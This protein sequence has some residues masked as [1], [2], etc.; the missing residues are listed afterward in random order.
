MKTH[1]VYFE[2][3]NG[4]AP[5]T[6]AKGTESESFEDALLIAHQLNK[7]FMGRGKYIVGY[8]NL[9]DVVRGQCLKCG[10]VGDRLGDDNCPHCGY[11]GGYQTIF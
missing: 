8:V 5:L 11:D 4:Q 3:P 2:P 1:M 7:E 6:P 10:L 9:P